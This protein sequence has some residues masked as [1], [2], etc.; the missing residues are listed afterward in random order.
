MSF[1]L[2]A[3]LTTASG[4]I[5]RLG[6]ELEFA[7]LDLDTISAKVA[8]LYGGDI[9]RDSRFSHRITGTRWGTFTTEIDTALLKDGSYLQLLEGLGFNLDEPLHRNRVDDLLARVA[10]T[11]VPHEIVTP[12]IP[13][14]EVHEL[15]A[16]RASLQNSEARGT[17]ASVFYAFGLHLNPEAA[18]LEAGHLTAIL[19]AFFL[20]YD[21]LHV[22][23]EI[24]W[25][26]RITPY[27]NEFPH[28]Y[29]RLVLDPGY[30]PALDQ[31][32]DDYLTYNA[33]RNRVL[34]MLPLFNHLVGDRAIRG[35]PD[36]ALVS[37]RPA[38]HYRLPNCRV[39][40]KQWTLAAEWNGW[41]MVEW[42][43]A[44]PER[45]A[46]MSV[47]Y[48]KRRPPSIARVDQEWAQ[49]TADWLTE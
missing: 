39:D 25:S 33:T 29:R 16:L 34:D 43:A 37:P 35:V 1:P 22:Q 20:L 42:L 17:R 26:R 9:V 49:Q 13:F 3:A 4:A 28:P 32:V 18:S 45:M 12:P 21:W 31:L 41:V 2:P 40:E 47:A 48:L 7:G 11:V 44:R 14:T 46:R 27:I 30:A 8:E 23:G 38:F 19:R 36:A 6:V 5:R 24:D 15:E 10:G